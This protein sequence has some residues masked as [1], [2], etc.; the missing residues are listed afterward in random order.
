[1]KALCTLALAALLLTGCTAAQLAGAG[2]DIKEITVDDA[3]RWAR[4]NHDQRYD[5]RARLHELCIKQADA[6]E[7]EEDFDG[8]R[9]SLEKCYPKL[10]TEQ[11]LEK[12]F[13]ILD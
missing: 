6:L 13:E 2:A 3:K 4:Q 9:A 11:A 5:I 7:R 10:L 8:A 1:M 12:E